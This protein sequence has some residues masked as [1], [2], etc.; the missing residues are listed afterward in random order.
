[1]YSG[2]Y[3][4]KSALGLGKRGPKR[5]IKIVRDNIR[6]ITKGDIRRLARRGGVKRI[7][8]LIYEDIRQALSNHLRNL[9][10]DCC[11]MVDYAQRKTVTVTDVIFALKRL[12]TPIYGFDP[13]FVPRARPT[14]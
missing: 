11:M 12:G 10:R 14:Q 3:G 9:L 8:A 7:S 5:H 6:C 13:E 4:G 1:V 2:S